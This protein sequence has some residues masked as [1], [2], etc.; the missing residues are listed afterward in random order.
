[1]A[2]MFSTGLKDALLTTSGLKEALETGG[3]YL[4]YFNG[5][6]PASADDALDTTGGT[7]TH[8]QLVKMGADVTAVENSSTPLLLAASASGGFITKSS[9]QTWHGIIAF[10]GALSAGSAG[11]PASAEA[12]FFRLCG[13]GDNGRSA[14]T[15][16][17][18]I[19][20]TIGESGNVDMLV[21]DATLIDNDSNVRGLS[22]VQ[23]GHL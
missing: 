6:V 11:S 17:I 13:G 10:S 22:A 19:Q 21:S 4:Y 12:T 18:R 15:T 9:S 14:S 7:G 2:I 3:L 20:G 23:F 16:A 5:P 8:T 1:M